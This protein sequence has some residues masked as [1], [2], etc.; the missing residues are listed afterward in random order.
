MTNHLRIVFLYTRPFIT[1]GHASATCRAGTWARPWCRR[2]KA[3]CW[4]CHQ[5]TM[6]P[7]RIRNPTRG[8]RPTPSRTDKSRR[9]TGKPGNTARWGHGGRPGSRCDTAPAS[10]GTNSTPQ[11]NTTAPPD[12]PTTGHTIWP[13]TQ[14]P[15]E[16]FWS[17]IPL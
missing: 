4:W 10:V 5:H 17:F 16:T 1:T 2:I 13:I 7:E 9:S 8:S 3:V 6:D 12:C 14:F 11:P 15:V